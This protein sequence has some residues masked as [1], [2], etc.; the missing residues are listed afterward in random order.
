MSEN[1]TYEPL[2]EII[3]KSGNDP[4]NGVYCLCS[5]AIIWDTSLNSQPDEVMIE[6]FHDE[7]KKSFN[8]E[9]EN[10]VKFFN[11]STESPPPVRIFRKKDHEEAVSCYCSASH[12]STDE[13]DSLRESTLHHSDS[14]ADLS[15]CSRDLDWEKY[16]AANGERLIWESWISKYG[17]Y[18]DPNYL[19]SGTATNAEQFHNDET[20]YLI[21]FDDGSSSVKRVSFSGLLDDI[22]KINSDCKNDTTSYIKN[23]DSMDKPV[24]AIINDNSVNDS[25]LTESIPLNSLARR[26]SDVSEGGKSGSG[27]SDSSSN[28]EEVRLSSG[29]RCSGNSFALTATTDSMTNVTRMTLSSSDS[30]TDESSARSN[31][32]LSSSNSQCDADQQWQQLWLEHFNEQYYTHYHEFTKQHGNKIISKGMSENYFHG[33]FSENKE[34]DIKEENQDENISEIHMVKESDHNSYS[35][36][37]SDVDS[38][39]PVTCVLKSDNQMDSS[40]DCPDFSNLYL[41]ESNTSADTQN[42]PEKRPVKKQRSKY[43]NSRYIDSVGRTLEVLK[44]ESINDSE[45]IKFNE[46]SK[47]LNDLNTTDKLSAE[48]DTVEFNNDIISGMDVEYL[49]DDDVLSKDSEELR[50]CDCN[51]WDNSH[52]S[53]NS[54]KCCDKMKDCNSDNYV[55]N[56][57]KDVSKLN[58]SMIISDVNMY[59]DIHNITTDECSCECDYKLTSSDLKF[60]NVDIHKTEKN[61]ID[62][63][64]TGIYD[65]DK[66]N[67]GSL[68][69]VKSA[70]TLMGYSFDP[71]G[72]KNSE[73]LKKCQ[74]VV[75]YKKKNIRL[76]NRLLKMYFN[77]KPQLNKHIYFDDDGEVCSLD[78]V[79]N[80]LSNEDNS[81]INKYGHYLNEKNEKLQTE[82]SSKSCVTN[83]N[84]I[85]SEDFTASYK[86][87]SKNEIEEFSEKDDSTDVEE[88]LFFSAESGKSEIEMSD[89]K[90]SGKIKPPQRKKKRKQLKKKAMLSYSDFKEYLPPEIVSDSSLM[91][92]WHQRYRLFSKYDEG[93]KLDAESW[94]SVTPEKVSEHIAERCRCDLVI[95]AFCGAGGNTIQL[96]FTCERVIAIDIDPVKIELAKNNAAVY[97]VADRIEFIIGDFLKLAPTLSADVV[98]LSPPWGGPDYTSQSSYSLDAILPP[99][100]G[101]ELFNVAANI[102]DNIAFFLPRNTNTDELI[103]VA[104]SGSEVEIEQDFLDRKLISLTAYFGELIR[105][106]IR[107]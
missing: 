65:T 59:Q 92:Y 1:N 35:N 62:K 87:S 98:F 72:I 22:N 81:T 57:S 42:E 79:K 13:H 33:Y 84:S 37:K 90:E 39:D 46:S 41:D 18:I 36:E 63:Q 53:D 23:V 104:G 47:E 34:C 48:K 6:E 86:R 55:D 66:S 101:K 96:A 31:S 15:E 5:R 50:D 17:N 60:N 103:R 76:Q 61:G 70:F 2:A 26:L 68:D 44:N 29:S 3:L 7:E 89:K 80:F 64:K 97:G 58:D 93:I 106:W 102:T 54:E 91:K 43:K 107:L 32:F 56:V 105:C 49:N 28:G 45:N 14:G 75:H 88:D 85:S 95:D 12:Y 73:E 94:Y 16:W 83:I 38:S 19:H 25:I 30:V 11:S 40:S 8:C 20:S 71:D 10:V 67:D 51:M 24:V 69:R 100:G 78:K 52:P 99:L 77:Y 82:D 21:Q 27:K 9:E 74:P 4:E